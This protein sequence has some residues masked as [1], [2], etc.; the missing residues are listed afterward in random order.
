[1]DAKTEFVLTDKDVS[2]LNYQNTKP[3]KTFRIKNH[4]EGPKRK[5]K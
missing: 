5:I 3:M 1:M 2:N 4:R